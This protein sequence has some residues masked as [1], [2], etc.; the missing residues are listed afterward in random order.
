MEQKRKAEWVDEPVIWKPYFIN[1]LIELIQ[2]TNQTQTE[3][4]RNKHVKW[5]RHISL[6]QA[7]KQT[8]KKE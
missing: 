1:N 4:L 7:T 5:N 8:E 6:I 3:T 2:N